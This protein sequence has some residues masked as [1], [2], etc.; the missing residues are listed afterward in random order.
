MTAGLSASPI[1]RH[2][3]RRLLIAAAALAV[4][5]SRMRTRHMPL[6]RSCV[7]RLLAGSVWLIGV[8]E[9]DAQQTCRPVLAFKEV[10][11][12]EVRPPGI[13]R[14]WTAVLGVDASHCATKAGTF[15]IVF[16]RLKENAPDLEFREHF[17]WQPSSVTVSV[18]F[19]ADES[20]QD[21]WLDKVAACPCR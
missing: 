1:V 12:S 3:L 20:V 10:R 8:P 6:A 11:F 18:D 17:I 9:A 19:W 14:H 4:S 21:F 2:A 5:L 7:L 15:E 13:E 16:S